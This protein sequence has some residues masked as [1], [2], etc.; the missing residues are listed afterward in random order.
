MKRGVATGRAAAYTEITQDQHDTGIT[1]PFSPSTSWTVVHQVRESCWS[2]CSRMSLATGVTTFTRRI[3]RLNPTGVPAK[4]KI[5]LQIQ[6]VTRANHEVH[7]QTRHAH[8]TI[9]PLHNKTARWLDKEETSTLQAHI[10]HA[11]S[12]SNSVFVTVKEVAE[13]SNDC[14]VPSNC[15]PCVFSVL[16]L[17]HW[18]RTLQTPLGSTGLALEHMIVEDRQGSLWR[19][20]PWCCDRPPSV[21]EGRSVVPH[22]VSSF[23][24]CVFSCCLNSECSFL[25]TISHDDALRHGVLETIE[26]RDL[27]KMSPT[28]FRRTLDP[29]RRDKQTTSTHLFVLWREVAVGASKHTC[30]SNSKMVNGG[31]EAGTRR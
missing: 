12:S 2:A 24:E 31:W 22:S 28:D 13:T 21:C 3:S 7:I 6:I 20:G 16:D 5:F 1:Q 29:L 23:G 15:R 18:G 27:M 17:P 14:G 11:S 10:R 30:R 25:R 9:P 26:R 8:V 4:R 19:L